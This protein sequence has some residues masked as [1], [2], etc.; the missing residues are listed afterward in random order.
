MHTLVT[1]SD[2]GFELLGLF[3][4]N[5]SSRYYLREIVR[6]LKRPVGSI[7]RHLARMEKDG[8]LKSFTEGNLKYFS[9][10]T[11]YPYF[12][13]LESVMLREL[14]RNELEKNLKSVIRVLK[15]S[16]KPEKIILF[17]S[18]ATGRVSP[19]GDLDLL[20]V[21]KNVPER[22]WDRIKKLASLIADF[23]VGIDFT[24]WTPKELEDE[25]KKNLFLKE[26]ILQKGKVVYERAA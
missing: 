6:L 21:K 8:V 5:P 15:K 12:P 3:F 13:E 23:S 11:N 2:K 18:L 7:Q 20:I 19:D 9:L 17:G 1:Q 4:R 26:E 22:Y 16:F 24:I 25:T 10:N 14:R